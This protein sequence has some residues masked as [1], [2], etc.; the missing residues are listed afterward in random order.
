MKILAPYLKSTNSSIRMTTHGIAVNLGMF[1]S[2]DKLNE[3]ALSP[4]EI[5]ELIK[6]L[7]LALGRPDLTTDVFGIRISAERY[8]LS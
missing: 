8:C 1:L 2:E 4:I 5:N 7:R 6:A 3:L